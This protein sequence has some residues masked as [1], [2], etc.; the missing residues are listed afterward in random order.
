MSFK[1]CL[2]CIEYIRLNGPRTDPINLGPSNDYWHVDELWKNSGTR[3]NRPKSLEPAI[4][5][6]IGFSLSETRQWKN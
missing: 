6:T 3:Y 1:K 2:P 5:I 4:G